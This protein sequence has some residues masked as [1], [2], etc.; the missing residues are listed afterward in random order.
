MLSSNTPDQ[1]G[2]IQFECLI[3]QLRMLGFPGG[4]GRVKGIEDVTDL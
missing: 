1:L 2:K 4:D 3:E